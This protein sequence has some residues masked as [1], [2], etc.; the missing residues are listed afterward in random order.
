[1]IELMQEIAQEQHDAAMKL[2]VNDM[3]TWLLLNKQT[4]NWKTTKAT[5]D[6][7]YALLL[8]NDESLERDRKVEIR[9][10]NYTISSTANGHEQAGT[11]YFKQRIKGGDVKPEIGNI[12]VTTSSNLP[13]GTPGPPSWGAVYWQY[14]EDLDKITP[15][16]TPLSLSKKLFIERNTAAGKVLLPVNDGDSLNIGDKVIIRIELRSDRDMEYLQLKDMCAASM[17]P[18]NVLSGYKWQDGLGYYEATKDAS[19]NFFISNLSKGTYVFEYPA[20]ITHAGNFSVGIANI[21][22]MYAPEFTSHS[23]GV[24]I[25]VRTS[26][27]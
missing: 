8:D 5:A 1:M 10:G 15:A 18:V 27:Q 9:L 16:A 4:N 21:Q 23:E 20:Y 14:F 3:R 26:N 12:T 13:P 24:R 7:C 17:E 6:A 2:Q 22:C 19:T 11:G 25:H